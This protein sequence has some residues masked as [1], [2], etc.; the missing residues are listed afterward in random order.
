VARDAAFCFTYADDLERFRALGVELVFFSPMHDARLPEG[1]DGLF[2]PGG[3]P[4]THMRA[5]EQNASMRHAVREA[6]EGGLPVYAECGGLMYLAERIRWGDEVAEMCGVAPGEAVMHS[7]PQGRGIVH[8]RRSPAAPWSP[9]AAPGEAIR[10]HEFHYAALE[11]CARDARAFAWEVARGHG[12]DGAHDGIVLH[13]MVAE[14]AH[15]RNTRQSPWVDA[16]TDFMR[17]C[18]ETRLT[19][20]KAEQG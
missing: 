12:I 11:E 4:E 15:L 2:L 10:A 18:K 14:F 19:E 17:Q 7:R 1:I 8:L 20:V 5:L 13:N 6:I 9:A 16:F 3:F